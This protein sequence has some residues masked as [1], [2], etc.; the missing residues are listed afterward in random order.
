M[1]L[2]KNFFE[3]AAIRLRNEPKLSDM[4]WIM[5]ATIKPFKN[6]FLEYCFDEKIVVLD[7]I[8]REYSRGD[9][10]PDFYFRNINKNEYIIENKINDHGDHFEQ[11]RKTFPKAK[12]SFISNYNEPEH[13]GW[14]VKT[15]KVFIQYIENSISK[16]KISKNELKY[17]NSFICYLKSV[18]NYL[19]AK[20]MNFSSISSL[21]SFCIL[22]TDIFTE[23]KIVKFFEPNPSL[24]TSFNRQYYGKYFYYINKMKQNVYIWLG[25]FLPEDSGIYLKFQSYQNDNWLPKRE[26]EI[27]E[28]LEK[29]KYFNEIS[30]EEGNMYIHLKDEYFEK[31]CKKLDIV[32]QKDL[33]TNFINEIL[34]TIL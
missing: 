6:I 20:S 1:S 31:F 19:E 24:P 5:C 22:I 29:G 14:K 9:S 23:H 28:K 32:E 10:Q 26:R 34:K 25:L 2:I 8:I 12:R 30:F 17:I 11:Y 13:D 15:W 3:N 21:E 16:E 4:I 18:I 27:L 33:L 7:E